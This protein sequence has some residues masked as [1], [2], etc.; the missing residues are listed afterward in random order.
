MAGTAVSGRDDLLGLFLHV[1]LLGTLAIGGTQSVMPEAHR[2]VVEAHGWISSRQ[3]SDSFALAQA[4]PGPNVLWVTLVCLQV[5]GVTGA[6]LAT[7]AII[8]PGTLGAILVT[9]MSR[10]NPDAPL[11]RAI[12]VGVSPLTIGFVFSS[13]WVLVQAVNHDWRGWL[14]TAITVAVVL[15]SKINPL[16]L[17]AIGA[18]A[19]A[20]G[21]V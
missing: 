7:F 6:L 18:I 8:L 3:F 20:A 19:G 5:A 4:S 11:G 21:L 10:R 13:G 14:L 2:F 12:R 9:H 17:I 1:L 16:W 15:R